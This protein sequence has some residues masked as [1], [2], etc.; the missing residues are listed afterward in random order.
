MCTL[1]SFQY[2]EKQL[3]IL[4]DVT[5]S[6]ATVYEQLDLNSHE[7]EKNNHRLEH[8]FRTAQQRILR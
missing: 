4:R 3:Q 2:L 6:K 5:E 7:L 1:I 8:D